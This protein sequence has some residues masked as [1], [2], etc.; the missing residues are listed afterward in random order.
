MRV[1]GAR[2]ELVWR[3]VQ[4]FQAAFGRA[5]AVVATAPGRVNLIGEHTDYSGGFVL[6]MAIER[7]TAV[8]VGAAPGANDRFAALDQE[9]GAQAMT[10]MTRSESLAREP[11][12]W[13]SYVRG[14]IAGFASRGIDLGAIDLAVTSDVPLG[15]GLSSSAALEVA[16]ATAIESMT[17]TRLGEVEKALLCQKAEHE[18]AGVPCGLMDQFISVMGREG[19]ALLIDCRAASAEPIALRGVSVL[20]INSMVRHALTGGEYAERRHQCEAAASALHSAGQPVELLR[21]V[22]ERML[23]KL[24]ALVEPVVYRRARHVV[25]ENARTIEAARAME[26]GAWARV[27][28]LMQASHASLRDDFEVSCH[29]LD[30]LVGYASETRGIIGCRMTGG[31]FG[32]CVVALVKPEQAAQAGAA[33]A[34]RYEA[35]TG[36]VPDWFVSGPAAGARAE[37]QVEQG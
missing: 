10:V 31:G 19:F 1:V 2:E 16:A 33:I 17:D 8:A 24:E 23:V 32:G 25:R 7:H 27:G 22:D 21:D 6:P 30:L 12:G 13:T 34:A 35:S 5:P 37:S 18:Y 3:C 14:V 20:I 15:S 29:E 26:A 9:A 11:R 4:G 28:A 36:V